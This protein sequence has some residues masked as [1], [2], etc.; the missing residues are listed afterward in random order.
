VTSS[1]LPAGARRPR[2]ALLLAAAVVVGLTA[3]PGTAGAAPDAPAPQATSS[4]D[5]TRRVTE[6][7][8][9]LEVVTEE[10]NDA[11]VELHEQQA[12]ATAA[13]EAVA[14]T[15]AQ[16]AAL[17]EQMRR[18]ARSAFTGENLSRFGALMTSG[19][20]DEFLAQVN[21]LD[22]LAGHTDAILTQV[23]EAS[24]AAEEAKTTAEAAAA[25]AQRTLDDVT[26]R[27]A[28][29]QSEI[30]D[31]QAQ[32]AALTA[33]EQEAVARAHAGPALEAP[34]RSSSGGSARSLS[35]PADDA[36]ASPVA[37]SSEAAQVAVDTALA[38]IGDPYV[39]AAGGPNAFDCSGLTQYAYAAAGVRLPHS[40][41]AQSTMGTAV[42]RSELQPGDLV[43][44]R[45]PVSHV[46]M[47]IGGGKMVHAATFGVPVQI[48]SV[49]MAGYAGARRYV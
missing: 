44:F 14:A 2:T 22:A 13:A 7:N 46:G 12:A 18:V 17:D 38:Q 4:Q 33:A 42:S 23:S 27:Q 37:A 49:D 36:D 5:A 20:A 40:S 11:T 28:H 30:T 26:A 25:A 29:L 35:A 6:A 43:F 48:T 34:A 16:L 9:D 10:V 1:V 32:Y 45:S 24:R 31:Y 8:H 3:L 19:S 21:T 15:Q 41:K 39:W 47:Y